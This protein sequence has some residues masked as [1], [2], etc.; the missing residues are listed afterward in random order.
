MSTTQ[1]SIMSDF[2]QPNAKMMASA[3][4]FEYL[5]YLVFSIIDAY[6]KESSEYVFLDEKAQAEAEKK[7]AENKKNKQAKKD[8]DKQEKAA[9]KAAQKTDKDKNK[10]DK[11]KKEG[12]EP[13]FDGGEEERG[14]GAH[15]SSKSGDRRDRSAH[16]D[17]P[18][19]RGEDRKDEVEE[20]PEYQE[21]YKNN[22]NSIS[23]IIVNTFPKYFLFFAFCVGFTASRAPTGFAVGLTYSMVLCRI[24]QVYSYYYY[25]KIAI[26]GSIVICGVISIML[27]FTGLIHQY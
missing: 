23:K 24:V 13:E 21:W 18:R 11:P 1:A 8:K 25:N 20:S 12:G 4:F 16:S 26:I 14:R 17:K 19:R 3:L 7:A 22:N 15:N 5:V 6:K 10:K 2:S 27:I 9:K